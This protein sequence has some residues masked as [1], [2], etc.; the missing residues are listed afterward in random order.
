MTSDSLLK[1]DEFWA[2]YFG[3]SMESLDEQRTCVVPHAALRGY[4]DV[5]AFRHGPACI[6]SVPDT[7]P[8]VG[9]KKLRE[10]PPERAFDPE[11]LAKSLVVWRDQVLPPAWVGMCAP[12]DLRPVSPAA[13]LLTADDADPIRRLAESCGEVAWNASEIYLRRNPI[14]GVFAGKDLVAASGYLTLGG[15]L[16][17]IGVVTHPQHRGKGYAKAAAAAAIDD[18][19][20]RDLGPMWRTAGSN[21]AAI[22]VARSLGFRPYALT[23]DVQ[24]AS[25]DF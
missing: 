15:V 19:L 20:D 12:S 10:V 17:Y 8:E 4:D 25:R 11:M 16:A 9:R 21:E 3:C 5:L 13:R 2:R 23:I 14:F 6:V 1:V 22:E 24:L 18:G 7:V